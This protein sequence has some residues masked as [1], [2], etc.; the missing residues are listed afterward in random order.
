VCTEAEA[1]TEREH[2][3]GADAIACIFEGF[4]CTLKLRAGA[5]CSRSPDC[6]TWSSDGHA[7]SC[8]LSVAVCTFLSCLTSKQVGIVILQ[9]RGGASHAPFTTPSCFFRQGNAAACCS[10]AQKPTEPHFKHLWMLPV[11]TLQLTAR[12]RNP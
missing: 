7:C 6:C 12:K 9:L 1:C 10:L 8:R 4:A 5:I 11:M 2:I 3:N